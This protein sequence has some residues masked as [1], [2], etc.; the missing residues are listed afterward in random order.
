MMGLKI[1]LFLVQQSA[2]YAHEDVF[3][4]IRGIFIILLT[5]PVTI[6]FAVKDHSRLFVDSK[7]EKEL[8]WAKSS[9]VFWPCSTFTEI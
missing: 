8:Q 2:S 9:F 7:R 5:L 4:N 6:V 1:S 3:P